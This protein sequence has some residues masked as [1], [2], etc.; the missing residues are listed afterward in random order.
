MLEIPVDA[1]YLDYH[2]RKHQINEDT[3]VAL[4]AQACHEALWGFPDDELDQVLVIRIS[5]ERYLALQEWDDNAIKTERNTHEHALEALHAILDQAM[6][7][8][9]G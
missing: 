2:M 8:N 5:P 7:G 1:V 9:G 6:G 4:L 3:V